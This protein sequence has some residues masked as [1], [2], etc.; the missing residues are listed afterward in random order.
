M[1][2][3][4]QRF[5]LAIVL[6]V[7][8]AGHSALFGQSVSVELSAGDTVRQGENAQLTIAFENV[9]VS[10][11]E[12]PEI[13]GWQRLSGPYTNSMFR[14]SNGVSTRSLT[15]VYQL[16]A[17]QPGL[18]YIPAIEVGEG[19][20]SVRSEAV[21]T[22]IVADPDYEPRPTPADSATAPASK[23]KRATVRM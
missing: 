2:S 11:F 7:S 18:A 16:I 19:E 4:I 5:S 12:L 3:C 14:Y 1:S 10:D 17:D 20:A 15:L 8:V 9:E 21:R 6:I 22:F 13:V 23:R